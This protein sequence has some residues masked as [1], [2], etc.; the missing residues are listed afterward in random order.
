M[1]WHSDTCRDCGKANDRRG[2]LCV[3]CKRLSDRAGWRRFDARERA[4]Q[5]EA[6]SEA[7]NTEPD[8]VPDSKIV[9]WMDRALI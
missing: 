7:Q 5:K 8:V 9:R 3:E 4:R 2:L 6:A 1:G